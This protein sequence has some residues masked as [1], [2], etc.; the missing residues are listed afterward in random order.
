[1]STIEIYRNLLYFLFKLRYNTIMP[2]TIITNS[3][4]DTYDFA[5]KFASNLKGGEVIGLMGDLG[6]G[7]TIFTKGLA[8][9]LGI[10]QAITSPTFVLM[11]LYEI[12]EADKNKKVSDNLR[13]FCHIDAYRAKDE[14][15]IM[16]IGAEDFMG[17]DDTI[18][19]VEWADKIRDILPRR[20]QYIHFEFQ[21]GEKRLIKY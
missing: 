1:M 12:R 17:Q 15:D 2:E 5:L 9:G 10:K 18:T 4:Q 14:L 20:T 21:G 11:R 19:V 7:K 8:K 6:S 16:S 13:R 3:E